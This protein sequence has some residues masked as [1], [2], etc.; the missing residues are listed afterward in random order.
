MKTAKPG[1]IILTARKK[2]IGGGGCHQL[3]LPPAAETVIYHIFL[4][5][6]IFSTIR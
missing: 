2:P 1:K 4:V 3:G 6:T 5:L